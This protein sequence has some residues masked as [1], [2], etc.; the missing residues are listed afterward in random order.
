[1]ELLFLPL[2]TIEKIPEINWSK[3]NVVVPEEG[4]KMLDSDTKLKNASET[5]KVKDGDGITE[6]HNKVNKQFLKLFIYFINYLQHKRAYKLYKL[7]Q[8]IRH[9]CTNNRQN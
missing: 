6:T 3:Y 8:I 2:L 9:Y 1:M 4:L 5:S 7:T